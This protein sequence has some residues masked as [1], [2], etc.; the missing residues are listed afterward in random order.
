MNFKFASS[1]FITKFYNNWFGKNKYGFQMFLRA[2][3]FII[4]KQSRILHI[5]AHNGLLL[6]E[7]EPSYAVGVESN[8]YKRKAAQ[9]INPKYVFVADIAEV[10]LQEFD[11]I[12][13]TQ[14]PPHYD[15]SELNT[16]IMRYCTQHTRIITQ[17]PR[18]ISLKKFTDI[19]Q[20]T[21][22][23]II[24]FEPALLMGVYIPFISSFLNKIAI[25]IPG[26]QKIAGHI[27]VVSRPLIKSMVDKNPSI[28]IIIPCK[29]EKGNI[30]A[31]IT[32]MP[33]FGVP[34]E[35]IFVEGHS[36]DNTLAE[37]NRIAQKYADR[38]IKIFVQDGKGKNDAVK[39]G[40][41]QASGDILM[42]LDSDLTVTPEELPKFYHALKDNK[43]EFINGSRLVYKMESRAMPLLN[44]IVNH[45]FG[46]LVSYVIGQKVKDTLCG[47]KVLY[48]AHYELLKADNLLQN[49]DPFG[50]FDLLFGAA[51]RQL[52]IIDMPIYYKSRTYGTTQV[53]KFVNGIKLLKLCWLGFKKFKLKQI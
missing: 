13:I 47:T 50:D 41:A 51:K 49:Q 26:M 33:D 8:I 34:L 27:L 52:K 16:I 9:Q 40:F 19:V 48:K 5:G 46:F 2:H 14:I 20:N 6:Q 38:D 1:D 11:I 15:L 45:A 12:L 35:F 36:Q 32:R 21:N 10:D 42:I 3:R 37:I 18:S 30:E 31:A 24:T 4:P 43:A 29:N 53:K 7:L 17:L 39:K 22:F 44:Y 25:R 28:S 23:E